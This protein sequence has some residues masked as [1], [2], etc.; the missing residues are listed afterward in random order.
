MADY[1][2]SVTPQLANVVI[3]VGAET[4]PGTAVDPTQWFRYLVSEGIDGGPEYEE[5][6]GITGGRARS[7]DQ[8]FHARNMVEAPFSF[9][10]G[11][12]E[13]ELILERAMGADRI[14]QAKLVSYNADDFGDLEGLT[15]LIEVDSGDASTV[16]FSAGDST[17]AE[18]VSR[19]NTELSGKAT[20]SAVSQG[21]RSH[22]Q[23]LS[24][25][26]GAT[27]KLE[28]TGGTGL[29]ALGFVEDDVSQYGD[30]PTG[31]DVDPL[32][33]E[34]L[35]LHEVLLLAGVEVDVLVLT[36][37]TGEPL[38]VEVEAYGRTYTP[39]A[40]TTA[41]NPT[42]ATDAV[43]RHSD[44]SVALAAAGDLYPVHGI[45]IRVEN[46]RFRD[47]RRN[48]LNRLNIGW[49]ERRV[50][51]SLSLDWDTQTKTEFVDKWRAG[52]ASK[53]VANWSRAS[54]GL[55]VTLPAITYVGNTPQAGSRG[56]WMFDMPFRADASGFARTDDILMNLDLTGA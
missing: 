30:I 31:S 6:A 42:W 26:D 45:E 21:G 7:A 56:A 9:H 16:T 55:Q 24:D 29:T 41:T 35:K 14:T 46:N 43:L 38:T 1:T 33:L 53:L 3:G 40:G 8:Y 22:I 11:A 2:G 36:S 39:G 34:V 23:I 18:A 48:S 17:T 52:T 49:G 25:T 12:D 37:R 47:E 51:G 4:T 13:L 10:P 44:V 50:T 19:I 28:I 54:K 32:T 15:L 5:I 20:A 27:S